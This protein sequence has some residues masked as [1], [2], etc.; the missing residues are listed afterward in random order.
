[1]TKYLL[2]VVLFIFVGYGF[3]EAWPLIKGPSLSVS[4]PDNNATVPGGI[5]TVSGTAA[6]A[7][8]LTLDGEPLLHEEDGS[9]STI[10]SFPRGGSILTFVATDRFGKRVTATRTVFVP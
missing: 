2:F 7:V 9:F 8:Q 10:L 3:V 6:R 4:F 1:M 5:V